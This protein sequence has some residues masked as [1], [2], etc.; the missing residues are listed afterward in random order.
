MSN[1]GTW[2]YAQNNN[3]YGP[4][5]SA[6][7]RSLVENGQ[8]QKTDLV[9]KDGMDDWRPAGKIS[10]LFPADNPAP[11]QTQSSPSP[12]SINASPDS[13]D[14]GFGVYAEPKRFSRGSSA[15]SFEVMN[16]LKPF[17]SIALMAGLI[18]VI[19]SRGCDSINV[20]NI[21]ALNAKVD[22]RLAKDPGEEPKEAREDLQS[23]RTSHQ[24]IGYF[25]EILFVLGTVLFSMGLLVCGF[26][27]EGAIRWISLVMLAIIVFS[28]Y[29]GGT[30]WAASITNMFR[31][32]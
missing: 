7:L 9:W 23:A 15:S 14:G 19:F 11:M 31:G 1:E 29:V 12:P 3:K 13:R 25:L 6:Q 4:V 20:R 21:A 18:V 27:G 10:G 26:A 8:L 24:K 5:N 32:M 16:M 22:E 30:A 28:I 17:G 2:Y